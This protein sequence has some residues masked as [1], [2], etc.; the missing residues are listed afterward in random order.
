MQFE[1]QHVSRSRLLLLLLLL[2]PFEDGFYSGAH[3]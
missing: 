3:I 1:T 2:C